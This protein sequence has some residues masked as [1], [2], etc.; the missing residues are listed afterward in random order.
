MKNYKRFISSFYQ[1]HFTQYH[2][3]IIKN[4]NFFYLNDISLSIKQLYPILFL[5]YYNTYDINIEK[6]EFVKTVITAICY[7]LNE[8]SNT[9]QNLY[10][11]IKYKPLIIKM[12]N[13]IENILLIYKKTIGDDY[14]INIL[15]NTRSFLLISLIIY[16]LIEQN[17]FTIDQFI[18]RYQ[19]N[20]NQEKDKILKVYKSLKQQ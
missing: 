5:L 10:K 3:D 4:N 12:I 18:H 15:K 17:K 9:T 8:E 14:K 7:I 13:S 1:Y 6:N 19:N 11:T 16:E 20:I 2:N